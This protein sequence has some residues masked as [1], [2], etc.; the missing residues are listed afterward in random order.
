MEKRLSSN[1][2]HTTPCLEMIQSPAQNTEIGL[3]YQN[4]KVGARTRQNYYDS[5]E[6]H[7]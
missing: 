3:N 2:C 7:F 5:V 6:S 1:V 4:A